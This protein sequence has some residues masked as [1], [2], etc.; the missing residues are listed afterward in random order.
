MISTCEVWH[1]G[2]GF[3]IKDHLNEHKTYTAPDLSTVAAFVRLRLAFI[4][5]ENTASFMV[6]SWA[7][8][9]SQSPH[10][11]DPTDASRFEPVML[12]SLR[13]LQLRPTWSFE[14]G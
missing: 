10:V 1:D 13:V 11:Y 14:K 5:Q 7:E 4:A 3:C 9:E 8:F 12:D 6:E 2:S